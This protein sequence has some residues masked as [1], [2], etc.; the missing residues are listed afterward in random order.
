[1]LRTLRAFAWLRWRVLMNSLER[2]GARDTLERLSLAVEQIGPLVAVGLLVP[3]AAGLALLG[4]Y[5]GY[6][7]PGQPRLV[8]FTAIRIML[9]IACGLCLVGPMLMPAM[10]RTNAIR[11]LLLP[12]SRRTL[13]V[14]QSAGALSDPWVLL[15]VPLLLGIPTGLAASG[16]IG[17]AV[18]SLAAGCLLL[19]LLVGLSALAT[20]ALHLVVRDRRR[21]ELLTLIFIIVLPLLGLLPTLAASQQTRLERRAERSARAERASRGEET[22]SER[23]STLAGRAYTLLP[24]ELYAA[25]TRAPAARQATGAIVP[26]TALAGLAAVFHGLGML[27][28]GRLLDSPASGARRQA[29]GAASSWTLRFP[30]LAR[31][32]AAVAQAQ[33]RLAMRTPRGRS[34]LISPVII[35]VGLAIMMARSESGVDLG[36]IKLAGGL[37]LTAFGAAFCLLSILPIAMNQFAI[38][39]AGLT[40]ALLSPI[41]TRELLV[42][43][44]IGNAAIAGGPALFCMAFAYALFREEG[45]AMW[46]SIP[47][48]LLGTYAL[49]APGAA[50]LSA[51]FP[52]N[53]DLNSIGRGSNAHG[54]AGL[55]GLL[56]F[57]VAG[58]PPVLLAVLSL[59]FLDRPQMTPVILAVWCVVALA[60]SRLL[61]APVALMFDKRKENLALVAR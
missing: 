54:A 30:G 17:A 10:E 24:S 51:I 23:A 19:V 45:L 59:V 21:G 35:F 33:V 50:A 56:L 46:S 42:G 5:T 47:L 43:K 3:S 52:R 13:Y 6:M 41:S 49:A 2:T 36:A 4:G 38:D 37:G 20:F 18:L 27:A 48:G 31:P 40:L 14:A 34:I 11:L 55:L 12:I 39:R 44:A 28:F 26:L 57:L 29:A 61:F 60:L 16:A 15:A 9:A 32:S 7:L 1:M 22:M 53:V 8:P 58:T 25:A